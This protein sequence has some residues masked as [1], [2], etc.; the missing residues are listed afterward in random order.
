MISQVAENIFDFTVPGGSSLT[1][2]MVSASILRHYWMREIGLETAALWKYHMECRLDEIMPKYVEIA[3]AQ[4]S[5]GSIFDN[6]NYQ[7]EWDIGTEGNKKADE[8]SGQKES[9]LTD[10]FTSRDI[11]RKENLKEK[12]TTT[13]VQNATANTTS[14][15]N[16]S[17][18]ASG[19]H[20]LSTDRTGKDTLTKNDTTVSAGKDEGVVQDKTTNSNQN[21]F[22]D[23]P[24]NGLDAVVQ[25]FY[26]TNATVENGKGSKDSTSTVTSS[27]NTTLTGSDITD[28]E[29]N[30][31][32]S[33]SENSSGSSTSKTVESSEGKQDINTTTDKESGREES[34]V[35]TADGNVKGSRNQE[36]SRN[37]K[38]STDGKEKGKRSRTGFTGDKVETMYKYSQMYVSI[39]Q[40]IIGDVADLFIS[41]F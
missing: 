39:L 14:D 33:G 35:D 4:E 18:E 28:T 22:S 24:Q 23:T 32:E 21:L 26:L 12:D 17:N 3:K 8:S 30:T 13:G 40:M 20:S 31:S 37:L 11:G 38:E 19:S 6:N 9:S 5:M 15:Y 29:S 2:E 36:S 1:K 16:T 25:G 41:I 34:V 27:M 7:E 10:T